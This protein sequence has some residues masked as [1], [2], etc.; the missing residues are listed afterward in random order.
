MK[1]QVNIYCDGACLGNPGP[2]GWAALLITKYSNKIYKKLIIGSE[3]NSTNNRMELQ[4]AI[5]GLL[6]LRKSY[7]VNLYSD[8]KYVIVG[9][10]QWIFTWR[11][12][13]FKTSKN[14]PV[15]NQ[16]LWLKLN[17]VANNHDINWYW[18]KG[19]SGHQ[20]NKQVDKEA[21]NAAKQLSKNNF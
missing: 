7:R 20:Q 13:G 2:G 5:A 3:K 6:A 21:R 15:K 16:K 19:H 11:K 18:I 1:P 17:E 14:K 8:S 4:S 9:M 10:K 12:N